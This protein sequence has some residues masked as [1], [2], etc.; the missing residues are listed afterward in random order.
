[1]SHPTLSSRDIENF[2]N[3]LSVQTP[4]EDIKMFLSKFA[5]KLKTTNRSNMPPDLIAVTEK[6]VAKLQEVLFQPNVKLLKQAED[7]LSEIIGM[8]QEI[9]EDWEEVERRRGYIYTNIINLGRKLEEF[10]AYL[11]VGTIG[12]LAE[13]IINVN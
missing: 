13:Q 11:G 8:A 1:M 5:L 4:R 2:I 10:V 6:L 9:A 12:L 3:N 7:T